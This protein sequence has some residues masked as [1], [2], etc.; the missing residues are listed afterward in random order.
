MKAALQVDIGKYEIR[1]VPVPEI[2]PHQCLI[3]VGACT[4]C[5]T[6]VKYFKG[7]QRRT[8]PSPMGHEITG[9]VEKVGSA[10]QGFKTGD[11]ILS[12][13]VWGGFAEYVPSDADML[14]HLPDNIGFEE[15]AIAQ[16]LPIAVRGAELSV[17]PGKTV[18]VSGLGAAGLLCV[19]VAKTYGASTV[20]AADFFEMKRKVALE[21]G[22]DLALDPNAEDV[23]KRVKTETNGGADVAMEAVGLEPS[24]RACE[25]A[26]RG[27]GILSIFGTHLTPVALD[28]TQW[29]GRSL[30]LHIMREQR[31]EM[32]AMLRKAVA[33][34]ASGRVRLKPLLSRVMKLDDIMA[35]FDLCI[36][37]PERHIKIAIVP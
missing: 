7:L 31:H 9:T 37:Q 27:G 34:L 22:A 4:V 26:V 19:Q 12:R 32:P 15:G 10:V 2:K 35:A 28:L 24:F 20:I 36:H 14:A 1:D 16:L 13:I 29:E 11:R 23:V 17:K 21:V 3:K 30:Q 33:L 6:D 25:Q 18:F 8:W 5:A